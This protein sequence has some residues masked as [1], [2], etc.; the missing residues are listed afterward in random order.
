MNQKIA[1]R[2]LEK[3][4]CTVDVASDGQQGLGM[5][6]ASIE[7]TY[8]A[9]LM[10]IRMPNMDGLTAAKEIRALHRA[11]AGS[12]PILAMTANA[13]SEERRESLEAGM[14]AHV[15]KPI[16]P[17]ELYRLLYQFT[18]SR[19]LSRTPKILVVDDIEM[20]AALV[21]RALRGSYE[22]ILALD[23][24]EA[25]RQLEKNPYIIAVIT[26]VQ[27]PVMDGGALI[28]AIRK[29]PAYDRIALIAN[30]QF[31]NSHV[32]EALMKDGADDFIYKPTAPAVI[33]SRV[34]NVL[35][36]YR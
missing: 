4:G 11:D 24:A 17:A 29:N 14:N 5:F 18:S 34:R 27:M 2:L 21:A 15:S 31:G 3:E 22:T 25:L 23:G 16:D 13:F 20:N 36:K 7:G 26:D 10:D 8:D 30:T 33:L 6:E 32:E 1:V 28:R 35:G 12:V 19:N 9:V